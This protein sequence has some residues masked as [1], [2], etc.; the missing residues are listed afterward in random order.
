MAV[1]FRRMFGIG[2]LP[3]DLR[4][5][6]EAEGL[7]YLEEYVAVTRRFT[8]AIPGL[9]ASHSIASYPGAL[10]FTEQRVLG[11]LSSLPKLAGRAVDVRWDAPQTGAAT[12]EIS[13]TGLQL[14]LDV[15]KVDPRF[16]GQLSLH[17]K[18]DID[19]DVLARLPLRSLAFDVP[20]E[21]V[22]RAVGVTYSP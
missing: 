13:S 9:R 10:A 4:D 21:Y 5:Q 7:I 12:A 1:I 11:T 6:L 19:E 3:A 16:H 22:F 15:A 14:D 8:G 17:F 2:K 18:T 20:P